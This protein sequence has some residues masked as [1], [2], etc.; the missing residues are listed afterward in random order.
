MLK[1]TL[2]GQVRYKTFEQGDQSLYFLVRYLL[3]DT[4]APPD[5][6]VF[7]LLDPDWFRGQIVSR[8]DSLTRENRQLLFWAASPTNSLKEQSLGVVWGTDTLWWAGPKNVKITTVEP[9]WPFG[10]V[11]SVHSF[12]RTISTK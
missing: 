11:A 7:L 4:L 12:L 10:G 2:G 9:L 8:M 3:R 1:R 5:G 6:A